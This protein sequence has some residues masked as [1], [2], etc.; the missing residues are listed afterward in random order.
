MFLPVFDLVEEEVDVE[1]EEE[2]ACVNLDA[3]KDDSFE[4]DNELSSFSIPRLLEEAKDDTALD[5][6]PFPSI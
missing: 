1:V 3:K 4:V 5:F 2:E 6:P